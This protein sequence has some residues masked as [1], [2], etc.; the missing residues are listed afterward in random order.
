MEAQ[1]SDYYA[2]VFAEGELSAREKALIALG[3]APTRFS[4][5]TASMPIRPPALKI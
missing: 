3:V 2:A 1:L 5:P 4:A